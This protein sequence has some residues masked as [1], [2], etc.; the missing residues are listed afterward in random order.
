MEDFRDPQTAREW[1]EDTTTYN[2]T[3]VEQL[4][5]ILSIVTDEYKAGDLILDVGMGS[6]LVEEQLFRRI[7]DAEVVGLDV[8]EA[9]LQLAHERLAAYKEHY[10]VVV[11]DL[12]QVEEWQLPTGEY[13]VCISVQTIHN[14]AD[15]YKVAAF[16]N[17]Y[18]ALKPGGLFLLLDRIAL[19]KPEL[20]SVYM[21]LW[22]RLDSEYGARTREGNTFDEHTTVVSTRGDLPATLEQHLHWL[23]EIGFEVACVHLHAN[24]ALFSARKGEV[25]E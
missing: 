2:P 13:G 16:R 22:K 17:I 25:G 8:S 20:F 1:S 14:V 23:H 10:R 24:R 19:D 3:R 5:I 7:P 12:M 18:R 11:Q 15:R 4:D 21:S 9:M 6:G